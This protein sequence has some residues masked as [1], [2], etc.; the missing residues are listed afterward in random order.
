MYNPGK[1]GAADGLV[2]RNYVEKPRTRDEE[3]RK[4]IM[5]ERSPVG[6]L[7]R[8]LFIFCAISFVFVESQFPHS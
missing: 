3:E 5:V 2:N 8:F 7:L 1:A 6:P 4:Q